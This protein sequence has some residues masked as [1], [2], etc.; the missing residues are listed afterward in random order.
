VW[1]GIGPPLELE[2]LGIG[3]KAALRGVGENLQDHLQ[4]RT[5]FKCSAQTL[6]DQVAPP[7][8][9]LPCPA[10]L[11]PQPYALAACECRRRHDITVVCYDMPTSH[12]IHS[13]RR[14]C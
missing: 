7:C 8:P 14:T 6:N 5:V 12:R 3:V 2:R 13:A 9:A 1:Q 11:H 4:I 10:R